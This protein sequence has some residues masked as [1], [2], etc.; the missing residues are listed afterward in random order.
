[1]GFVRD[2]AVAALLGGGWLADAFLVAFRLPNFVRRLLAEGAFAYTLLPVYG[3]LKLEDRKA[4]WMFVRS[5]GLALAGVFGSLAVSGMMFS[6]QAALAL[7]PGLDASPR[8]LALAVVFLWLC[9][10]YLPLAAV[11]A[12]AS[13]ALLAEGRFRPPALAPAALNVVIIVSAGVAFLLFGTG[14]TRIPYV[15]CLGVMAGGAAQVACQTPELRRLGFTFRGPVRLGSPAVMSALR[16]LPKSSFGAAGNQANILA[17]AFFASFLGEGS[18]SAL[19]FAE[20]LIEFPVGIIGA[21]LGLAAL[22]DLTRLAPAE[23]G[24][25]SAFAARLEKAVRLALFFGLPAAVGLACLTDPVT[26]LIFGHGL[27]GEEAVAR[28]GTAFLAYA[29]GLPALT[30]IRPLLA[31]LGALGDAASSMRASLAGLGVTVALGAVSLVW[32]RSWGPALAVSLAAWWNGY[33]LVRALGR[34]GFR[35]WPER[36]WMLR[37]LAACAVMAGCVSTAAG[38]YGPELAKVCVGIPVGVAAY[39]AAAFVLRLDE[40]GESVR[41]ALRLA[42][43][44]ES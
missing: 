14:D 33:L 36:G 19:Y 21:S 27:F 2:A 23:G 16:A 8:T 35:P 1:M 43:G 6:K 3:K 20:R 28:T 32:G 34:H 31:G 13:A 38:A 10:P 24:N 40:A 17:A 7:A 9:L 29:V 4:A 11:S 12:T 22:A 37:S 18:I 25:C 30:A 41:H 15:L 5:T 44:K 39:F 42:R 26:S